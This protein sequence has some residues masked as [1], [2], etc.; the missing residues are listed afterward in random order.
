MNTKEMIMKRSTIANTFAIAAITAL[1]LGVAPAAKADDKGC[2]TASLKG[3]FADSASGFST[4]P[5][6]MA[7]P[8]GGVLAETFD[9]YGAMAATGM[10]SL[11]GTPVPVTS[12]GTY[13]VNP[14]CTGTYAVQVSPLGITAHYFFVILDSGDEFKWICTDPGTV[15]TGV[16]R[17]L[18][19]GRAI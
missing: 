18:Y 13:T 19:P 10:L 8:L 14:D 6:A 11:N 3:T 9:G 17:K 7:G 1:A 12:K 15:L 2:S 16:A 5:P 4:A